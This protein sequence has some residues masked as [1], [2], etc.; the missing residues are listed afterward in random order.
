MAASIGQMTKAMDN[1]LLIEAVEVAL[2]P[3]VDQQMRNKAF[4]VWT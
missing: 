2:N 4:E 3:E 1:Q